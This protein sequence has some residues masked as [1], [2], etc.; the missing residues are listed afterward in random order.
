MAHLAH[1][2]AR[3]AR[4][5]TA[6]LAARVQALSPQATLARGYAL[7]SSGG[8]PASRA[9]S[10]APGDQ[11]EVRWADG[12]HGAVVSATDNGASAGDGVGSDA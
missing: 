12:A 1:R 7:V 6:G 10:V 11:I 3:E 2:S 8:A 5:A 4:E 9:A